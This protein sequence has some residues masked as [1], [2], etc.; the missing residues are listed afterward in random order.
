M[1]AMDIPNFA[2][3][4][5]RYRRRRSLTQEELAERAG[6]SPAAISLLERGLTQVPQKATVQM[7]SAALALAPEEATTF[8]EAARRPRPLENGDARAAH[9]IPRTA[10]VEDLPI[11]LTPLI[12][13]E[14]DEAT[15]LDLL[16]GAKTRLLTL[17]G[18]AGVGKTRLAPQLAATLR[19]EHGQDVVFVGLIP[20]QEPA[21]VLTTIAQTLGIQD[22]GM[23]P[24]RDSLVHA[25]R[26]RELVLVLDNFEHV[27]PAARDVLD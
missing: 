16:G 19:R 11:P 3:L 1:P 20:V 10:R 8:V 23:V 22:S 26:D 15:L 2:E 6:I 5:R 17:I 24:L 18:P 4:L 12:G 14:R 21:R 27:L 7:L 13:R 25:L 9:M